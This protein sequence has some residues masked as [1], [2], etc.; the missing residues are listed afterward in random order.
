MLGLQPHP[1][2]VEALGYLV[3]AVPMA[4]FVLWP[5]RPR[6][7][8]RSVATQS[9]ATVSLLLVLVFFVASCGSADK[10]GAASSDQSGGARLVAVKLTDDGCEPAQLKLDAGPTTFQISNAGTSKVSEFE[11]LDG[12]RIL[13]EKE[14]VVAGLSGRFDLDLKPGQY[15]I[16]CPG[17]TSSATGPLVVGGVAVAP[18]DDAKLSAATKAYGS[19]VET[20][21]GELVKRTQAFA[22][23]VKA[24]DVARAKSLFAST[25]APY[26]TIEPVA[27][28]FGGLDPAIDARV[29]DVAKGD[30]WTGFHRLEQALWVKHS[31]KGMGPVADRLLA[32]VK[33]LQ[34]KVEGLTYQPQ[35]MTNGANGLLDEVSASKITGEEDRY[36]HTDLSDFAANVDGSQTTF[37][38]LAPA[39]REKDPA[40]ATRIAARFAAV[41]HALAG[42]KQGDGYPSYDTVDQAQ[43]R[44][45]SQLVDA[46]AEPLSQVGSQ[47]RG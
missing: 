11:V 19:Y 4:L 40:L 34:T 23:A 47:L 22:G 33:R 41:N 1:V 24:G 44:Q 35:E 38:L 28:S 12:D 26:E 17:G 32:D 42:L 36:S 9:A 30:D 27:E 10:P 14:N 3:Y 43:R 45:L 15:T 8:A 16:S 25:R 5:Q 18:G 46:L 2:V 37:G 6:Q 7:L 20:Q 13:G 21:A 39:L 29:N 31:T